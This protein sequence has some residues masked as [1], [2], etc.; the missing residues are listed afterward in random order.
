MPRSQARACFTLLAALALGAPTQADLFGLGLAD[1]GDLDGDGKSELLVAEGLRF[2]TEETTRGRGVVF[3]GADGSVLL[4]VRGAHED[5]FFGTSV[6]GPGDLDGDG[7]PDLLV[8][9]MKDAA[10]E[11]SYVR[12][13]AGADGALLAHSEFA[14][15]QWKSIWNTLGASTRPSALGDV[16][17]DGHPDWA[18]GAWTH[19]EGRGAVVVISGAT[20]QELSR[21]LG[22]RPLAGFGA[23][24]A[25]AG[26]LDQDGVPE[27]FVGSVP[28]RWDEDAQELRG[29]R[30]DGEVHALSGRGLA[31]LFARGAFE[32]DGQFGFS[33]AGLDDWNGDGVRDLAVGAPFGRRPESRT[34]MGRVRVLSGLDGSPLALWE[35]DQDSGGDSSFGG[36]VV[37][38]GTHEGQPR[39][40]ASAVRSMVSR[41]H[42]LVRGLDAPRQHT[43]CDPW[44]TSHFGVALCALADIDGD[45]LRDFAGAAVSVRTGSGFPG[46]V[47][48]VSSAEGAVLRELSRPH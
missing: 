23:S 44:S 8:G 14:P 28:L 13:F 40:L 36:V 7:I 38:L 25:P 45:G 26:D 5:D 42:E 3:S 11:R 2:E 16:D 33:V 31:P 35:Q 18:L 10:G 4:D 32:G 34:P 9:A 15:G 6:A 41:T 21:R 12:A 43:T 48:V 19:A 47:C 17:R 22:A 30:E 27:L 20:G 1:V 46:R 24:L 29:L 37:G 39:L